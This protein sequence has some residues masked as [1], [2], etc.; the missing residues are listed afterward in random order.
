MNVGGNILILAE[1]LNVWLLDSHWQASCQA[2]FLYSRI[3]E[4]TA[5]VQ[6]DVEVDIED[7]I[8]VCGCFSC[9]MFVQLAR[10]LS[11]KA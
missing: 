2:Q 3:T 10:V 9:A 11:K 4:F 7:H 1:A 5:F 6:L 8:C